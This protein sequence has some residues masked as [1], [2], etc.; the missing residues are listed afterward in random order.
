LA[1]SNTAAASV[2]AAIYALLT[3]YAVLLLYVQ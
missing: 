2:H 1:G 3:P